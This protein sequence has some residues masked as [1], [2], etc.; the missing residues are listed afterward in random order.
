MSKTKATG[1]TKLGRDSRPKF[2]GVKLYAGQSAKIG[3]I[4]VR[5]RGTSI[6]AG[7]NV[8]SGADNTLYAIAEGVV[9][10]RQTRK[11]MFDGTK[12]L[13]KVA[14]VITSK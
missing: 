4:L 6:V 3:S 9:K 11:R 5:Q 12:R 10:Y 7:K 14:E 2:L 8:K 13:A 1:G